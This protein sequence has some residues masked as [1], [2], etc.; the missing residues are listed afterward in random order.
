MRKYFT[1]APVKNHSLTPLTRKDFYTLA[2][3]CHNYSLD[4]AGHDQSR[5]SL[6]HCHEFNQWLSTVQS[7]DLLGPALMSIQS[8]RP[9]AR[10]QVM[11]L[12]VVLGLVLSLALP[13]EI[14]QP[15]RNGLLYGFWIFLIIVYF[16]PERIYGTTIELL[17]AKVLRV[18]E[19]MEEILD[20]SQLDFTDAA[21]FQTKE[22]LKAARH[23][24]RQQLDLAYRNRQR[25]SFGE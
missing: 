10:W 4:L 12:G 20:S 3:Y 8:A 18:V 13:D 6:R 11:V 17:E 22:N 2:Q 9:I 19:A 16:I 5:V 14:G 24:L 21:Y 23:E 15:M 25:R 7:Y 1:H